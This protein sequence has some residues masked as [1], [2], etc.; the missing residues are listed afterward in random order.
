MTAWLESL[1]T[2]I[3][4]ERPEDQTPERVRD[5]IRRQQRHSEILIGWVQLILGLVFATLWAV[6]PKTGQSAEFQ[7]V[8][9]ALSFYLLFTV[10]RLF[11]AHRGR[12]PDW[13]VMASI[14]LDM[15]LLMGLIWSFHVQY[16]QPPAFYLKA[17]T[18]LYV[19]IFI[20]LRALRFEAKYV[21][22][23]GTVAAL[24]WAVLL[25]Y[26]VS[27]GMLIMN[28]V[29]RDYVAYLTS[30]KILIGGEVD[31]I[32]SILLVTSILAVAVARGRR[33]MLRAVADSVAARDLARFV[34]PETPNASPPPN[35]RSGRARASCAPR[36]CCSPTS[37]DFRLS[38]RRSRRRSCRPCSTIISPRSPRPSPATAARSSTSRAMPCWSGSTP[39]SRTRI[40]PPTRSA[41]RSRSRTCAPRAPSA[42]GF[43][44]RRAAA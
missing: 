31:K 12:L 7:S 9:W 24:G 39:W 2:A 35:Y 43:R 32:L 14:V 17:P 16:R 34:S 6:A 36:P 40:T 20:A 21:I 10:A 30:N 1:V 5:I 44:S 4:G 18:L 33:I 42:P 25:W 13:A 27:S 11:A 8:P 23:A 28:P 19:F 26:S 15:A 41:P 37:R 22:A 38:R 29:T 3:L